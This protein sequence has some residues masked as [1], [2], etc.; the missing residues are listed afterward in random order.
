[1]FHSGVLK[2]IYNGLQGLMMSMLIGTIC[3]KGSQDALIKDVFKVECLWVYIKR[4][5]GTPFTSCV[6]QVI[7]NNVFHISGLKSIYKDLPGLMLSM[8]NGDISLKGN[9]D[10]PTNDV[11]K[12][13]CL[14]VYITQ[15]PG[16]SFT[17]CLIQVITYNVFH[18]GGLKSIYKGL[19]GLMLSMFNE[20]IYLKG[21]QDAPTKD[22]FKEECLWVYLKRSTLAY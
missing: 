8:L 5:P 10:A 7:T 2:S 11:F 9:Q 12:V 6:I 16:T 17:S 15:E 14:W 3:F 4:E 21:S 13:G 22:V 20:I 1:M 19:P 18:T